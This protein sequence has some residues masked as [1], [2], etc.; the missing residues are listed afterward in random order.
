PSLAPGWPATLR[1]TG[2]PQLLQSRFDSGRT[3]LV[4]IALAGSMSPRIGI[5]PRPPPLRRRPVRSRGR[6]LSTLT[7]P[8]SVTRTARVPSSRAMSIPILRF[9]G[10]RRGAER[11]EPPPIQ[12]LPR[13]VASNPLQ[14]GIDRSD[15]IVLRLVD[16]DNVP[17]RLPRP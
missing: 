17:L 4:R 6:V 2:C 10:T 9:G 7:G 13:P 14:A 1:P 15:K 16:F 8:D 3:G 12:R 11:G 5:S